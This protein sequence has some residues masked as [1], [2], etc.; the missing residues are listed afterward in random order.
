MITNLLPSLSEQEVLT[1][2]IYGE[3]RGEPIEGQIAVGCVIRNRTFEDNYKEV[4]FKPDQFSCWNVNDP[5]YQVLIELG[6]KMLDGQIIQDM[7]LKQC[8]WIAAG[9]FANIILDNTRG[10]KNYL[11]TKMYHSDSAPRWTRT[12]IP[13]ATKG[14]HTFLV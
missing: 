9:I 8:D 14:N 5:N 12:M 11:T 4:C 3:A 10:A 1:L 6:G 13:V 2:T 7:H